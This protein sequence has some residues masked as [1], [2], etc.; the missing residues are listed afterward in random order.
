M[1]KKT[2]K[3]EESNLAE[4]PRP[5]SEDE[6]VEKEQ[7]KEE[8]VF[9]DLLNNRRVKL[10]EEED[11]EGENGE[12]QGEEVDEKEEEEETLD[13]EEGIKEE[14][15][16]DKSKIRQDILEKAAEAKK[17]DAKKKV[18]GIPLDFLEDENKGNAFIGR[19]KSVFNKH[20]YGATFLLGKVNEPGLPDKNVYLDSMNPHVVFVCGSRGSGKSYV[21]GVVAEGLANKNPNVGVIVIDPVGVFWS[22]RYPNK[23]EKELEKL[24]EWNL[25]PQGLDNVKVFVPEGVKEKAPRLTYDA[26]FS[27]QPSLLNAEDWCL[28]FGIDRFSPTGLLLEKA[29]KKVEKGYT[30]EEG[31]SVKGVG[32]K[33]GIDDIIECLENDAEL[34]SRDRGYK[35]DS[36]RALVSRFEAARNWGIFSQHGTGLSE[37]SKCGQM[38]VVDT[39]FLDDN[40]T[41]LIIG[42]IARR[43]LASRK[44]VTRKEAA[45]KFKST[46]ESDLIDGDI[47][48]TWLFIDEAHTL[49]PSG[50]VKTPAT[51]A[52]VE[53]V[54]QG[55]RPGCSLV[56][57]TQQPSAI[58]TKVLSQLDIMLT[59][60]LVFDDDIKSVFR[61]TPTIVPQ[62]FKKSGMIRTLPIGVALTADRSEETSRAFVMKIRPRMS[63]HE[64]R[65]ADTVDVT[66]A[67]PKSKLEKL[68]FE[69][70]MRKVK[71]EEVL[72]LADAE[73]M[74]EK[75]NG[76]YASDVDPE[77]ILDM[78]EKQGVEIGDTELTFTETDEE[79][80]GEEARDEGEQVEDVREETLIPEEIE[81]ELPLD[82]TQLLSFPV[83]YDKEKIRNIAQKAR[84]KK[85]LGL[86]G[87]RE[88]LKE[89][90]LKYQTVWKA[91]YDVFKSPNEFTTMDCY[92]DS[93]TGEFLH[94]SG[95]EFKQSKGLQEITTRGRDDSAVLSLISKKPI[96]KA[97]ISKKLEMSSNKVQKI[98]QVLEEDELVESKG[99]NGIYNISRGIDLPPNE[100]DHFLHSI[101]KIPLEKREAVAKEHEI[102]NKDQ[103]HET[104]EKMWDGIRIRDITEVNRPVYEVVL[105]GEGTER[106]IRIDAY[107]GKI[108][109]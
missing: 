56:F 92:V 80:Q 26:T 31:N 99:E 98:L 39:S 45:S 107:T 14:G 23:E 55:R 101:S 96:S 50:N 93:V 1:A 12:D 58:D 94:F 83:Q 54:K 72:A 46:A 75:L 67:M 4:K 81:E 29:L 105:A 66:T 17:I 60:K 49:I 108:L 52:L 63:Q 36:I 103:V 7:D 61:R 6:R 76:K 18:S 34:N 79:P 89:I 82:E 20:G 10:K 8:D 95:K 90:S 62:R 106:T 27:V 2:E 47:P 53:Y 84:K 65:D 48:P 88:E 15:I 30:D 33:F 59:H 19:K 16:V 25:M 5:L 37:L 70:L 11:G 74:I 77:K 64:G 44:M 104:L 21:L 41:A 100:K 28:T 86:L 43:V 71:R 68:A 35:Q 57:A 109:K 42:V 51:E 22:M 9:E 87:A 97:E 13:K 85:L 73:Q 24:A 38:T 69:M 102:V 32:R 40:V 78:L 3:K 91:R